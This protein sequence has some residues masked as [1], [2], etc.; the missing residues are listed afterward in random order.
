MFGEK[1]RKIFERKENFENRKNKTT[2]LH[3]E[4]TVRKQRL[5]FLPSVRINPERLTNRIIDYFD[6]NLKTNVRWFMQV[7]NHLAEMNITESGRVWLCDRRKEEITVTGWRNTGCPKKREDADHE[8][9]YFTSCMISQDRKL[10]FQGCLVF[11]NLL[12]IIINAIWFK[13]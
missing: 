12:L 3:Q 13:V 10:V 1:H 8:V 6:R 2:E 4:G 7:D 9:I 11:E 5:H